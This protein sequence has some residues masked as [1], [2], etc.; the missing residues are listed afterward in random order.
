METMKNT[1]GITIISEFSYE[2]DDNGNIT[3]V[4]DNGE[5]IN[6]QYDDL[7]RLE[8]IDKPGE[9]NIV[10]D[11]DTRGNRKTSENQFIADNIIPASFDYNSWDE[12]S[13]FT[14]GTNSYEYKYDPQGLRIQKSEPNGTIR[15]HLDDNGSV[16][17]ETDGEDQLKAQI[18]LGHKPLTRKIDGAYYY[19]IYNGHG[20]VIQ[21][22]DESGNIVNSYKYD[23][24]GN[25][26]FKDEEVYNP[27]RYAGEYFDEESG[28]YYLRARYYESIFGRF[29][30]K[31][32]YEGDITNPL[33]LNLYTYVEN[34]RV[35]RLRHILLTRE[36]LVAIKG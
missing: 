18:I 23:E 25:L 9:R 24:W 2:Y 27:I 22:V 5:V 19:Y 28:L 36:G 20:D 10:Y 13:T 4:T 3:K 32:S 7:N 31:D 29:I 17:A 34:N 16:I 11:Y 30:S 8:V 35:P 14:S 12:M 6:Y 15:Y 26:L 1:L 21:M 33:S